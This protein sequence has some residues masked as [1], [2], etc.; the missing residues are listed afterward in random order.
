[1]W[2]KIKE[3]IWYDGISTTKEKQRIQIQYKES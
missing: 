2:S 3:R 1:M